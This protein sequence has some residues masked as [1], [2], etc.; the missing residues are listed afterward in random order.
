MKTNGI[1]PIITTLAALATLAL[2]ANPAPPPPPPPVEANTGET[3]HLLA[4]GNSYSDNATWLI[5]HLAK[6]GGKK[7]VIGHVWIG[8][9]SFARH[10]RHLA[11][12]EK[13]PASEEA[14]AYNNLDKRIFGPGKKI[15]LVEALAAAKW[16]FVSIQQASLSS[17]QPSQYEPYGTRL[18]EGIRRHAP[19]AEILVHETWAYREDHDYFKKHPEYNQKRMYEILSTEYRKFAD[20]HG[21]RLIPTGDAMYAASQTERWTPRKD[22]DFDY[23]NPPKGK[24]PREKGSLYVGWVWRKDAQGE[25]KFILDVTHA[26]GA[27][28]YVGA[29]AFYETIFR[30]PALGLASYV[31]PRVTPGEA[32]DLRQ[33][34]HAAVMAENARKASLPKAPQARNDAHR[35]FRLFPRRQRRPPGVSNFGSTFSVETTGREGGGGREAKAIPPLFPPKTS[36]NSQD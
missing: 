18:I 29:L 10:A 8:G 11:A 7:L 32:T 14:L 9:C 22:P 19:R 6:A 2:C 23:E 21:L 1:A 33:F 5:P 16:D 17:F 13:D 34:V 36:K 4:I 25:E 28:C 12:A 35:R 24:R 27:G 20:R 26:S 15:T 31:P 3:I 30:E